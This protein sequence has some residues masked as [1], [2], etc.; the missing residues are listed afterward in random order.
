MLY[1]IEADSKNKIKQDYIRLI[2]KSLFYEELERER[3]R[4]N[5]NKLF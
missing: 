2:T 5:L 3:G 4:V 1:K